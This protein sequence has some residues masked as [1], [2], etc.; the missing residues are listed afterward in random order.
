[1]KDKHTP[2]FGHPS[3]E[4]NSYRH[5]PVM[6]KEVL[7]LAGVKK[8][9]KVIDCTLGGAGYTL[10]LAKA[11]G[12]KGQ[13]LAI[14]LDELAIANAK[15]LI[16]EIGAKNIKLIQGNFSDLQELVPEEFTPVDVVVMD[17]GLSSAQ[18]DD[19]RRGFSFQTD[20][21]LDM[22][23]G[24]NEKDSKTTVIVNRYRAEDLTK[25]IRDYGEERFAGRIAQ[26]IIKA[27]PI[28]T[29]GQLAEV[30]SDAVPA[31]YRRGHI[32]C[33]T[34]TFQAIRIA[35]N[36]ELK[37]LENVLPQAMRLLKPGGR[38]VVVSFHSL[39]D[40]I[41]KH[42]FREESKTCHCD[43]NALICTCDRAPRAEL[44]TKKALIATP[45]EIKINPRSRSAKLRAIKKLK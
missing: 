5:V 41:V 30:I 26:A 10:A 7:E 28:A 44:L 3:Q 32:H 19:P 35:T 45:E 6:L 8:G 15:K 34:R 21:P 4:G 36:D 42:W 39:E 20:A 31:S 13:V 29:T 11:V 14:D 38:L 43:A 16:K 9:D 1:M 18:L 33:A 22:S 23:F 12:D 24:P 2:P 40:R 25:I 27:R 17:L 37:A